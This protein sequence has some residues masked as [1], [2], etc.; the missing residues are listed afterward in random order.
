MLPCMPSLCSLKI[1]LFTLFIFVME[2]LLP[3][4]HEKSGLEF[5]TQK[6]TN[7][8]RGNTSLILTSNSL[9]IVL[10]PAACEKLYQVLDVSF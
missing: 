5:L 1:F 7:N 9:T 3:T 10:C 8:G 6:P 4:S 2:C